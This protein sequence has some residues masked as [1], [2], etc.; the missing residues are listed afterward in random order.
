MMTETELS[1]PTST[2]S[3]SGEMAAL[4]S[5]HSSPRAR[6][7]EDKASYRKVR[8]ALRSRNI[9]F[10]SALFYVFGDLIS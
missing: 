4:D 8:E 1:S 7:L 3:V 2:T 9:N 6:T 10:Y 5:G